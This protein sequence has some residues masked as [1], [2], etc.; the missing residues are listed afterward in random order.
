MQRWDKIAVSQHFS[1]D[2][3]RLQNGHSYTLFSSLSSLT[4]TMLQEHPASEQLFQDTKWDESGSE[5]CLFVPS[6][7]WRSS[8]AIVT[9]FKY[10]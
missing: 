5:R 7:L 9:E 1:R 6:V 3:F 2:L 8:T 4:S 10:E